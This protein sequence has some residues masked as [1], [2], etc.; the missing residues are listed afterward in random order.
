MIRLRILFIGIL[1]LFVLNAIAQTIPYATTPDWE[2]T[3][4]GHIAT[5]LGLADINGDGWKDIVAGNGNDIERQHL[6]VYYNN[7]DGTFPLTPDWESDD[8]DYHGHVAVGDINMDGFTD[9]VVSVYLGEGGFGDPGKV[10]VY[11]NQQGELEGTPSFVSYSFYTFSC[12]LGDADGDGDLD[13]ATTDAEPYGA[14]YEEGN[15]FL[16]RNGFFN[17]NPDW[18]SNI[19]IGSM[20][21]EFA[22]VDMNGFLDVIYVSQE[23]DNFIFLSDNSGMITTDPS[24]HSEESIN[25][26]NS[27][28][29]GF[30]G[31]DK[32]PGIIMTGNN[33]LGGDG[34]VRLY[35]FGNGVPA[36]ST[37]SWTSGYFGYGSGIILSDVDVDGILDVIYG[38][39]W[40]PVKIA[41]GNDTGFETDPSYTSATSSV[42]EA[43]Q[44]ADL[45][46]DG[47]DTIAE[48]INISEPVSVIYLEKQLIENILSVQ[49]NG[50]SVSPAF[51]CAVPNK[52]WI[53]FKDNLVQGD[54]VTVEYEFSNDGEMV[55]TNWDSS[56]GNY[57]FYN[58]PQSTGIK[59]QQSYIEEPAFNIFP[60]PVKDIL[61]IKYH[62][63]SKQLAEVFLTGL[64]GRKVHQTH[65]QWIEEGDNTIELNTE[66]LSAGVYQLEFRAGNNKEFRKVVKQN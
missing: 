52:N 8:I 62:S 42:V 65:R 16:N 23:T 28:D 7:G 15:I 64:L 22:D 5:G 53:S 66:N 40:L 54:E 60:N 57:I 61:V 26:I 11:Y 39:W 38:G 19:P 21:V 20:D 24:W 35:S 41:L 1:S 55:I 44:I 14:I 17:E 32:I 56:K 2:S 4:E 46:R 6:V 9:V 33:Q 12:A 48:T 49:L 13:L 63:P 50:Q 27:V 59:E 58:N 10:K 47:I 34:K 43:I 45:D 30:T 3:A 18:V 36:S 37:A 29:F 25:N 51:Y 31:T